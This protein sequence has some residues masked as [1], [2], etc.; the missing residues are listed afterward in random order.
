MKIAISCFVLLAI[1]SMAAT[2]SAQIVDFVETFDNGSADFSDFGDNPATFVPASPDSSA[3]ISTFN[4][5]ADGFI[6]LTTTRVEN[7]NGFLPSGGAFFGDFIADEVTSVLFDIRHDFDQS[8]DFNIRIAPSDNFPGAF[9][10]DPI[11]IE[12]GSEFQEFNIDVQPGNFSFEVAPGPGV[13]ESIFSDVQNFQLFALLPG[14]VSSGTF[15]VDID[16][17][18]I[19]TADVPEPSSSMV[20]TLA[21]MGLS[22][23]RRRS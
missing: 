1:S 12:P 23:S 21:M 15:Q 2:S 17:F 16:N 3:F 5:F 7:Q 8:L 20:L 10:L 22:I 18:E 14:G 9:L 11:T 4:D 13:F 19:N 6:F